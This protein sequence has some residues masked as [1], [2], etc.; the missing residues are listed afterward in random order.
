MS[1]NGVY[2]GH[3]CTNGIASTDN[4]PLNCIPP[5]Q[6]GGCVNTGPFKNYTVNIAPVFPSLSVPELNVTKPF[7]SYYPRCMRRDITSWPSSRWSR[8]VDS[9]NLITQNSDI[10]WFQTMMQ[11]NKF[12]DG[13]FGVH[14]AGHYTFGGD[15]GGDFFASPGDPNFWLHHAQIDRTWWIWQNQ[16]ISKREKAVSGTLTIWDQ[17]PSRNGTLDDW[18]DMGVLG[19][20]NYIRNVA[21]TT[22]GPLC[23]I[24]M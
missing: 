11:G 22:K 10:Y 5:G 2:A 12:I 3:N 19:T 4:P 17:P 8:D 16:D 20:G 13:F 21:S 1:G 6:G 14:T 18:L 24:Y 7:L 23:Y 15:P 9:Y